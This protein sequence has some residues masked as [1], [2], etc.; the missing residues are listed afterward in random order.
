MALDPTKATSG[1]ANIYLKEGATDVHVGYTDEDI[2]F[3]VKFGAL[4][5]TGAQDGLSAIDEVINAEEVTVAFK[6]KEITLENLKRASAAARLLEDADP[7]KMR[8]E[9]GGLTGLSLR[10]IAKQLTIKPI[11]GGVETNDPKK[12]I[13]LPKA[14]PTADTLSLIFGNA[15]Q[16]DIPVTFKAWPDPTKNNRRAY[17]GDEFAG[18]TAVPNI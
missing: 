14:S 3:S 7:T 13:V 8:V 16:R 17:T 11:I 18:G 6:F 5:L 12:I 1:S 2:T 4:A 10:S 9:W 15:K